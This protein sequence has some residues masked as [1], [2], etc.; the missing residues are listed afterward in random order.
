[1]PDVI[2]RVRADL[3][4]LGLPE[5]FLPPLSEL[6]ESPPA[7]QRPPG[8]ASS[9]VLGTRADLAELIGRTPHAIDHGAVAR[10]LTGRRVL[11]T[12]AGGSIGAELARVVATFCP[13]QLQ[14]MD[15][16]E[17]A[18]FEIDRVAAR[19]APNLA[20]RSI[21][22][23]VADADQ[24][25]ALLV[26]LRPHVVFHAAAHKHVPLMEDHPAHAVA[27]NLFGTKSIADAAAAVGAERFVFVSTD[28]AVNPTSVMGATK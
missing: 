10:L 8:L 9:T 14:L 6:L 15:R 1:M 19:L 21:L 5:R 7:V 2:A 23:D 27:N 25:L 20:R 4:R 11:I 18:L 17:N 12:G 24:T 28:K 22:H 26:D 16:S 3:A 13:E